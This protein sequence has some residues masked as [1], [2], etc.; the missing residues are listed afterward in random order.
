[1][2][3]ED[4]PLF[5]ENSLLLYKM[6]IMNLSFQATETQVLHFHINIYAKQ[7]MLNKYQ[8]FLNYVGDYR[9]QN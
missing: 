6:M 1:M 3:Y 5:N 2:E 8:S 4:C 7:N 9:E